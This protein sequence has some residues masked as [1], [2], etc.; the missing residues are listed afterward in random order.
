QP[1]GARAWRRSVHARRDRAHRRDED[2]GAQAGSGQVG[3]RRRHRR[4]PP[5]RGEVARKRADLLLPQRPPSLGSQEPAPGTLEPVQHG[6]PQG[7]VGARV[8]ALELDRTRRLAVQPARADP[9]AVALPGARTPRGRARRGA[10]HG[11]RRAPAAAR[12]RTPRAAQGP[13]PHARLLS[14]DRGDRVGGRHP[15][16]GHRGDAGRHDFRTAG[17]RHRPR[18]D[19][20]DGEEEAGGLL[21][22]DALAGYLREYESADL[23]RFITCGSVDDGKSTLIG[24]LLYDTRLPDDQRAALEADSKRHGTQGEGID[25]ALLLDG[26]AA[27]REQGITI[28]VAYRFFGTARRRFIVADCPGHEQYTR[29]M[30]TGASTAQ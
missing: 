12:R 28:D 3:L 30:A 1:R 29:N 19:R 25:Y 18:S 5:R 21:L 23:L 4:C 26:L 17:A 11:G 13:L 6:R 20:F 22:M 15:G 10:D 9:G 27:E 7:R 16:E 14:V 8:P 2:P 24:R